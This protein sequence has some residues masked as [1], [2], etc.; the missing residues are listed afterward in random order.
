M[1]ARTFLDITH[2]DDL[3]GDL[4]Y[5][6]QMLAAEIETYSIE[7]RYFHKDQSVV[8]INLTVAL[9]RDESGSPRYFISVVEDITER[10][11][12]ENT[13]HNFEH[14]VS[15]TTDLLALLDKKFNY[16]IANEAY[17]KSFDKTSDEVVGH[18][19]SE[20][21][22]AEFF[23]TVIK[24]NAERCFAGEV[25]NYQDW[26]NFPKEGKKYMDITYFPH[27]DKDN[28]IKGFIV[29][30][31]D[32]TERKQAET[33]LKESEERSQAFIRNAPVCIHEID[34][35]GRISS[36]NPSGL[37]MMGV[38]DESEVLGFHYINAVSKKDRLK[39]A[40][41]MSK[42]FQGQ[43]SS[44]EFESAQEESPQYFSSI[45]IPIK[46]TAN[47]VKL[48]MGITTDITERKQAVEQLS[49]QASHDALTGL[50]NR[51]EFE[52]RTERLLSTVKQDKD[53][54][55]LCFMDLDQFKEVNDTC[56]HSAG[57]EMLRQLSTVLQVT[58]R[59]RD[60]LARLG[61]DEFGVLMEHC[62][63][64]N[65]HRVAKSLQ[66]AIKGYQFSWEG[67]NF[68]VGISIG[69]ITIT[70]DTNDLTELLKN[71]DAACYKAKDLGRNHIHV[72]Q[73]E[74]N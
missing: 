61:G 54:H 52:R 55:A 11:Q 15:S 72:Y 26:F 69:L 48:L 40:D 35:E 9:Q 56:G 13:L 17:L 8:W 68:T 66:K 25:I 27:V 71:A 20:L 47:K 29:H 6:R 37:K 18:S 1:L 44:F 2:P 51:R 64:K 65:A 60:T 53:E 32:I 33:L 57:D 41:L 73:A 3:E 7:K 4:E 45:F 19:V 36:M 74:T 10:K 67:H 62:S 46:N 24:P 28:E 12:A 23:N 22:G 21:F 30:G 34:H 16:I 58:V 59:K 42:A 39:V 38:T 31:R 70:K 43:V 49:H 14:I 50:V 63:L 5:V